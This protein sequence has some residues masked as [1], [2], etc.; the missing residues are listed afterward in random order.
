MIN[1]SQN[2]ISFIF[3]YFVSSYNKTIAVL[4]CFYVIKTLSL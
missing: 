2:V 3:D 1:V 4:F